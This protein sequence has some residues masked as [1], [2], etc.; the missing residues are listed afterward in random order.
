[1]Q[2]YSDRFWRVEL[3]GAVLRVT[4]TSERIGAL[5]EMRESLDAL[6]VAL[7]GARDAQSVRGVLMDTRSAPP[8][9]NEDFESLAATYRVQL[10]EAF[11]R[12]ATLVGTEVGKLQMARLD[13]RDGTKTAVFK[14]EAEAL[15]YLEGSP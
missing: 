4:R 7:R 1:M 11:E 8:T 12:V 10:E 14:D 3:Q 9:V 13:R 15:A 5:S 2:L 6:G